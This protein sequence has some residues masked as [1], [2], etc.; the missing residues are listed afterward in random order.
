MGHPA[1][2]GRFALA[3]ALLGLA[4][5]YIGILFS[6]IDGAAWGHLAAS[7]FMTTVFVRYVHGRTVPVALRDV[8]TTAYVPAAAGLTGVAI[9]AGTVQVAAG[10]GPIAFACIGLATLLTLALY[11][12]FVIARPPDRERLRTFWRTRRARA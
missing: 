2:T 12:A 4:T 1:V 5:V 9:L 10:Q 7:A 6:G 8:V 11:A 3:R